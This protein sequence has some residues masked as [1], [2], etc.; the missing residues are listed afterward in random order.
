LPGR[1]SLA[2]G[3]FGLF[4]HIVAGRRRR[5]GF[6]FAAGG[7]DSAKPL[8]LPGFARRLAPVANRAVAPLDTSQ[9][10]LNS[11]WCLFRAARASCATDAPSANVFCAVSAPTPNSHAWV[12][13]AECTCP[14]HHLSKWTLLSS[15]PY[16]SWPSGLHAI[17]TSYSLDPTLAPKFEECPIHSRCFPQGIVAETWLEGMLSLPSVS[18]AV[19]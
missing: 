7:A 5:A 15:C 10:R 4:G 17:L 3:R 11:D 13:P 8:S 12:E 19:T 6:I 16:F 14:F 1:Y 2:R 18:T 9:R